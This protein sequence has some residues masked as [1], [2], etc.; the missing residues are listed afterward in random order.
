M[1]GEGGGGGGLDM[2]VQPVSINA[3]AFCEKPPVSW[4]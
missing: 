4:P 1:R 3:P 2:N